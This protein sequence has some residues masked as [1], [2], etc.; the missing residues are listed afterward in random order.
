MSLPELPDI[1]LGAHR[2]RDDAAADPRRTAPARPTPGRPRVDARI[3]AV[4]TT[5]EPLEAA[6]SRARLAEIAAP[7][8]RAGWWIGS[9]PVLRTSSATPLTPALVGWRRGRIGV[10]A[11]DWMVLLALPGE[12]AQARVRDRRA[13]A[14]L[15][16]ATLWLLDPLGRTLEVFGLQSEDWLLLG[17]WTDGEQAEVAPLTVPLDMGRLFPPPPT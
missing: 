6:W 5:R 3:A 15:G 4:P 1:T 13:A 8:S 11:P 16:V 7:L 2:R 10:D 9:Q 12:S 14:E 17:A